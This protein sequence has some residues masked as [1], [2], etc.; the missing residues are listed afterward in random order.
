MASKPTYG[1]LFTDVSEPVTKTGNKVTIIGVGAVGMACAFA[2][3]SEKQTNDLVLMDMD[4]NKLK[5]EMLD[6]QQGAA[7]LRNARIQES[8]DDYSITRDSRIIIV[9]AGA[10]QRE[11]ESRLALVQRNTDIFKSIIPK[12]M[13]YNKNPILIIVSNPVDILTYVAWKLSGLPV[14]KVIGTGTN[15]DTSRFKYLISQ[16]L[17]IAPS[18]CHGWIIGEHGDNSVPVW[19]SVNVSGV[20]LTELNPKIGTKEDE[21][22]WLSL[23]KEV[24]QSAYEIIKLKGY[25]SWAIGLSVCDIVSGI[26]RNTNNLYALSTLIKGFH[27]IQDEVFL[28][29]PAAVGVDGISK[30]VNQ[31]LTPSEVQQLQESARVIAEVQKGIQF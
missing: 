12:L 5:G 17:D 28:S 22:D 30:V 8:A 10:R 31:K 1:K 16:R 26:M 9:T 29:L 14:H 13:E 3:L 23:H 7:F 20:R 6:L 11:G 21:E 2:L 18:S 27:C 4:R 19:S 25:T 24:V 15:L